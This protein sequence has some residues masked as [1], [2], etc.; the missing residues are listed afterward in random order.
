[1]TP[2]N[3]FLKT[4][5]AVAGAALFAFA[6]YF[7]S[8]STAAFAPSE[9][10]GEYFF[11]FDPVK[12]G[13]LEIVEYLPETASIREL[14]VEQDASG[15]WVIPSH[16]NYPTDAKERLGKA[17]SAI[18]FVKRGT[19]ITSQRA[20]HESLGVVD[21][22]TENQPGVKGIGTR[23]AVKEG[24]KEVAALI[25]GLPDKDKSDLRYVRIAGQDDVYLGQ[26]DLG[27]LSTKF[28]DWIETDLLQ[29][30]GFALRDLIFDDYKVE[31]AVGPGG[32]GRMKIVPVDLLKASY[33]DK[34]DPKDRWTLATAPAGAP[35]AA[36]FKPLTPSAGEAIDVEALDGAKTALDDLKIVDVRKKPDELIA[37][38]NGKGQ[39]P[40]PQVMN[41]FM[42]KGYF[43]SREG[44]LRSKEGELYVS[45]DG[46]V[47]YIL[48]FGSLAPTE[49]GLGGGERR[50]LFVRA[51]LDLEQIPSP[52]EEKYVPPAKVEE[53]KPD[54]PKPA[55][56][57]KPAEPAKT[58]EKK[59][60]PA[61]TEEGKPAEPAKAEEK[62]SEEKPGSAAIVNPSAEGLLAQA[63]GPALPAAAAAAPA[64]PA[65]AAP[66]AA[67]P[68]AAPA[69]TPEEVEKKR[70]ADLNAQRRKDYETKIRTAKER[71]EKLNRRFNDWYYVIDADVYKKVHLGRADVLK[72]AGAPAGAG[73]RGGPE[74]GAGAGDGPS[75]FKAL[76]QGIDAGN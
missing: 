26:I 69:P 74:G 24:G 73:G 35:L 41:D 43:A 14:K 56:G 4:T 42:Q 75:D 12:A 15:R 1:M 19:K 64:A 27:R 33:D 13:T 44:G 38:L 59:A 67:A 37:A 62:K 40:S 63:E 57:E 8:P 31:I 66:A 61:K 11:E 28:E 71:V 48:M 60:E 55:E 76:Q 70:I 10:L 9:Q 34:K 68:A 29:M 3:E 46:G 54:A 45:V 23:V 16:E 47:R 5:A 58:E 7:F 22:R 17:A 21:P 2:Q 32:Q 18:R 39:G 25:V 6:V 72:K 51:D 50:Y 53:K 52:V 49:T 20:D 36:N 65:A 30:Q